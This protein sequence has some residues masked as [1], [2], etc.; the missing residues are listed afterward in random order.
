MY[1]DGGKVVTNGDKVME[2]GNVLTSK[3][4]IAFLL[5]MVPANGDEK[6]TT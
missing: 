1:V 5:R 6:A 3:N 2:G 4:F